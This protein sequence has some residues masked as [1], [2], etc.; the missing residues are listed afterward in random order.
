M[1]IIHRELLSCGC[2]VTTDLYR[3]QLDRIA[4]KL[5]EKQ[6]QICYLHDNGRPR[7]TKS[8]HAKLLKLG[9]TTVAHPPYSSDLVPTDY[10]LFCS[11]SCHL[12][13]KKFDDENNV[14]IDLINF[15][16]QKFKDFYERRILSPP[17][18]V[19]I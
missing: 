9:P 2:T 15:F 3:Q 5:K 10:H 7:I 8:T 13:E 1:G 17:V 12:R 11:L 18:M 4:E 6:N 14:K 19:H 16:G